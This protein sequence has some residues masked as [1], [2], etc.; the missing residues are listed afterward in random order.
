MSLF[1]KKLE[2]LIERV[3]SKPKEFSRLVNKHNLENFNGPQDVLFSNIFG[4]EQKAVLLTRN[5]IEPNKFSVVFSDLIVCV[6]IN[7]YYN[8]DDAELDWAA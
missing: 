5:E 4:L 3:E 7:N 8:D 6:D 1:A 2:E